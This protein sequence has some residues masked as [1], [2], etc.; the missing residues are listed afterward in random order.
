MIS[1][2]CDQLNSLPGTSLTLSQGTAGLL[3]EDYSY[4]TERFSDYICHIISE[5]FLPIKAAL[6]CENLRDITCVDDHYLAMLLGKFVFWRGSAAC[7]ANLNASKLRKS[8][9][10]SVTENIF[11]TKSTPNITFHC[12]IFQ[13]YLCLFYFLSLY[14]ASLKT[15]W[16]LGSENRSVDYFLSRIRK[17]PKSKTELKHRR[18]QLLWTLGFFCW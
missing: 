3:L 10:T 18:K 6:L 1:I 14:Y 5:S 4:R 9:Q 12:Y 16:I 2:S 17:L 15:F 11:K 13:S 8:L 7:R